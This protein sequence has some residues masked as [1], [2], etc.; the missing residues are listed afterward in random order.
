MTCST[1]GSD[2]AISEA[3]DA[4][5]LLFSEIGLFQQPVN[6]LVLTLYRLL[7]GNWVLSVGQFFDCIKVLLRSQL[8]AT[9]Q[10]TVRDV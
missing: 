6:A 4:N 5:L 2:I 9:K 1:A 3:D 8:I 7:M 10:V